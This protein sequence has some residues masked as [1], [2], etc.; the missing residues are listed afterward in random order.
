VI[1]TLPGLIAFMFAQKLFFKG[2]MEGGLKS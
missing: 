2:L 1:V